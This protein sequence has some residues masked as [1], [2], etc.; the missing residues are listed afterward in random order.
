M[1]DGEGLYSRITSSIDKHN[2]DLIKWHAPR[3]VKCRGLSLGYYSLSI[4]QRKYAL[5]TL[6]EFN[7]LLILIISSRA[8]SVYSPP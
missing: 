1:S 6:A 4:V 2:S 8:N 3:F 7:N 5:K